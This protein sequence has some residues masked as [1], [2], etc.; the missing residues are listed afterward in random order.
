MHSSTSSL[1]RSMMRTGC[2]STKDLTALLFD[3]MYFRSRTS[4][5]Q[6]MS[7]RMKSMKEIFSL[8]MTPPMMPPRT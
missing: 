4:I 2:P 8:Y 3:F 1:P 7:T 5:V 6:A